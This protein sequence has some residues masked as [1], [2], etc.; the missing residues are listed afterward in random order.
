MFEHHAFNEFSD[1]HLNW[2]SDVDFEIYAK[3]FKFYLKKNK[4]HLC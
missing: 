2:D 3:L 1:D 4:F